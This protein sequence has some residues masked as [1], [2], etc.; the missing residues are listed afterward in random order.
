M[1]KFHKDV[2][3]A[4]ATRE[5]GSI[6]PLRYSITLCALSKFWIDRYMPDM[7]HQDGYS[8]YEMASKAARQAFEN[9]GLEKNYDRANAGQQDRVVYIRECVDAVIAERGLTSSDL[10]LSK[11]PDR[12]PRFLDQVMLGMYDGDPAQ[13]LS[14][15]PVS[16]NPKHEPLRRTVAE[17]YRNSSFERVIEDSLKSNISRLFLEAPAKINPALMPAYDRLPTG[18]RTAFG[19]CSLHGGGGAAAHVVVCGGLNSAI[20]GFSGVFMNAAMYAVGPAVALAT[21]YAVERYRLNDF[22]PYKYIL[23]VAISLGAAFAA[24]QVLPHEHHAD[25]RMAWFYMLE[26]VQRHDVLEKNRQR[27]EKLSPELRQ[28]VDVAAQKQDMTIPMFMTSLDVCGGDLTPRI[29]TF[30]RQQRALTEGR[31]LK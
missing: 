6:D 8:N 20:G 12:S 9:S 14:V 21:T 10:Y 30:E 5:D 17:L 13:E 29:W 7:G 19:S 24:N 4:V 25:P 31:G 26:P 11:T 1:C 28:Q 23:P 22:N 18:L 2:A 15:K 3:V 27:Y 16:E